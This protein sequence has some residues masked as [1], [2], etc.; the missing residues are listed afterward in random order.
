MGNNNPGLI[1]YISLL[2]GGAAAGLWLVALAE[3]LTSQSVIVGVVA[4][5]LLF[6]GIGGLSLIHIRRHID[7]IE[8]VTTAEEAA[9]YHRHHPA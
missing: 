7:P 4:F 2:A 1:A 9:I 8:P 3:G 5:V 6:G